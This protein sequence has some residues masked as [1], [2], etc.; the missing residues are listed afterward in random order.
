MLNLL[1]FFYRSRI[2]LLLHDL[3]I[4]SFIRKLFI[5]HLLLVRYQEYRIKQDKQSPWP[6][7]STESGRQNT[8]KNLIFRQDT[9]R[10]WQVW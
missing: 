2:I 9:F 8:R 1:I 5:V 6:S 10:E 7:W 3:F 4:H